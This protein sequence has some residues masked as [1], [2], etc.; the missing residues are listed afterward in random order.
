MKC[1]FAMM[2]SLMM[3]GCGEDVQKLA[4]QSEAKDD[5][6]IPLAIP[7]EACG[8]KVSKATEECRQCG[9]PTP[10]SVIAYK[11]EQE[12]AKIRLAEEIKWQEE[13]DRLADIMAK[14]KEIKKAKEAANLIGLEDYKIVINAPKKGYWSNDD[15]GYAKSFYEFGDEGLH[16]WGQVKNGQKNGVWTYYEENGRIMKQG[17]YKAEKKQG[18]WIYYDNGQKESERS[19]N[20]GE[21]HGLSIEWGKDGNTLRSIVNYKDGEMHGLGEEYGLDGDVDEVGQYQ[22]GKRDGEWK[23][24]ANGEVWKIETYLKGEYILTRFP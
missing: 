17:E 5:P 2:F 6:S 23:I 7:C 9:H 22:N 13:Q 18:K 1:V 4:V 15:T 3:I 24:Y 11:K 10:D 20:E 12:L 8:E 21:R 19:Y 16:G 14:E